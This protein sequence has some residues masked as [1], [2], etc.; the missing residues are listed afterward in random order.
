MGETTGERAGESERDRM[1]REH[2]ELLQMAREHLAETERLCE[3][4]DA[5]LA[6]LWGE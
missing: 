5:A 3:E 1:E 2:P 4:R 6:A